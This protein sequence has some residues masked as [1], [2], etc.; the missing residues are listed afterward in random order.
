MRSTTMA[1][2]H[3]HAILF[4]TYIPCGISTYSQ[5]LCYTEPVKTFKCDS[6]HDLLNNTGG[7]FETATVCVV[8]GGSLPPHC[9]LKPTPQPPAQQLTI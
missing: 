1:S 3:A 9:V 5:L 7:L 8:L 2:M 4:N 6:F